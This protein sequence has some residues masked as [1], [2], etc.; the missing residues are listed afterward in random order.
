MFEFLQM[1]NHTAYVW[2]AYGVCAIC[3]GALVAQSIRKARQA[4]TELQALKALSPRRRR[5][6]GDA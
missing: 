5:K 6:G 3:L 1:G 2:S 4:D